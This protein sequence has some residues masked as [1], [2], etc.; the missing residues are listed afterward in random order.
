[1]QLSPLKAYLLSSSVLCCSLLSYP[2]TAQIVPDTTLPIN[3]IVDV[4]GCN[5]CTITGGTPNSDN[6]VLFHSFEEFSVSPLGG[7]FFD[8]ATTVVNIFTRVT[9]NNLSEINGVISTN[10][11]G[12]I[13]LNPNGIVFLDDA[14]LD[15]QGSFIATTADSIDFGSAGQFST[16][17]L[18]IPSLLTV[19][20]PVG[21]GFGTN[22]GPITSE[23]LI[24]FVDLSPS[25]FD[26]TVALVGGELV[27]DT[28]DLFVG[29]GRIELGSAG[30]NSFVGLASNAQGWELN[31]DQTQE[32]QDIQIFDSFIGS[33]DG[34]AIQIQGRNIILS[35]GSSILS[36]NFGSQA[37]KTITIV[38]S[39]NLTL[40]EDSQIFTVAFGDGTSGDIDIQ[41]GQS[42]EINGQ[43]FRTLIASFAES[44]GDGG[45]VTVKAAEILIEGTSGIGTQTR[46]TGNSGNLTLKAD[47]ILIEDG[48]SIS[49]STRGAGNAGNLTVTADQIVLQGTELPNGT[50]PSGLFSQVI[51]QP[52]DTGSRGDGGIITV[53]VGELT[54]L[55]G[56]QIS[57]AARADGA[58]GDLTINAQGGSILLSGTALEA[59]PLGGSSGIFTSAEPGSTEAGGD[60]TINTSQ[61]TIEN[62]AKV[63]ADTLGDGPAGTAT[64]NVDRLIIQGGGLLRSG[65]IQADGSPP[66]AGDGNTLT[67][68]ATESIEVSGTGTIGTDFP[69]DSEIVAAAEGTGDAGQLNL[70]APLLLIRDGGNVR[71]NSLQTS[72]GQ[73]IIQAD[74]VQLLGDG[75]IVTAVDQGEGTGGNILIEGD[76][77]VATGDS[78]ILAFANEGIGGNITLPAF[79]GDNIQPNEEITSLEDLNALDKNGRVNVNATGQIASGTI[80]FPDVSFIENSLTELPDA[81]IDT[82]ALVASSC[83]APVAQQGSGR[84]VVTGSDNIPQ[85]PG[86]SGIATITT[87][88]VRNVSNETA[89]SETEDS[90]AIGD[91]ISEPQ[92]F[93]ELT[94]GRTVLSRQCS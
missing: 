51:F 13:L 33:D 17:T 10:D 15:I 12:L 61:L 76:A 75:D 6:T 55:E 82:A 32:F 79:F 93:Y 38:T 24:N 35:A 72:G 64:L 19:T 2:A 49:A 40:Q 89:A 56:A 30:A 66:P 74:V 92:A 48:G 80:T 54:L 9:G 60:L 26:Q 37:G 77:V 43:D 5:A 3:S 68:N 69:V 44:D 67:V 73:I 8:E 85:Q 34:G 62:G 45:D 90:W 88:T 22:P 86:S 39:E 78:D 20:T 25:V 1:M 59:T 41:V 84:L 21:L 87:G 47:R 71:T 57:T 11:A 14:F 94:D 53:N 81:P 46:D 31:Y 23:P 91:P 7:A 42:L 16:E 28:T 36:D 65:S 29:S 58:G 70:S 63:S 4:P 52:G 83:I 27:I 18:Q 50:N